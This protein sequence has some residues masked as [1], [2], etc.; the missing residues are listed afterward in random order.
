MLYIKFYEKFPHF[1]K[2][3]NSKCQRDSGNYSNIYYNLTDFIKIF[4]PLL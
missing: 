2:A 4:L 3:P 1:V